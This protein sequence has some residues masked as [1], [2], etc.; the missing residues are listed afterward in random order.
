MK[1]FRRWNGLLGM[2]LGAIGIAL[3]VFVIFGSWWIGQTFIDTMINLFPPLEQAIVEVE[4]ALTDTK[5]FVIDEQAQAERL[6]RESAAE[7]KDGAEEKVTEIT[8][9]A[10][11][12]K[13]LLETANSALETA[14]SIATS[15]NNL[16]FL[17]LSDT[18]SQTEGLSAQMD[19]VNNAVERV[20]GGA[21]D[22]EENSQ[23]AIEQI[24][25]GL[26]E[27]DGAIDKTSDQLSQY[28]DEL[29][30]LKERLPR[31]ASTASV[32]L[33]LLALWFGWAQWSL[34]KNSLGR[35]RRGRK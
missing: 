28:S 1:M 17:D 8:D 3:S 31:Y 35:W 14:T 12:L 33:T 10:N 23:Q 7:V 29:E 25:N 24:D 2:I 34:F 4:D 15:L 20:E 9:E 13:L 22:L 26:T 16:P 32:L 19:E 30:A 11:R 6:A 18:I 27:L 21:A 5:S